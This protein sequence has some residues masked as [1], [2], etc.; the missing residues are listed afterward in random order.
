LPI[1]KAAECGYPFGA[2]AGQQDRA[3]AVRGHA[4]GRLL[5]SE[6]P[7][8]RRD[9]DRFAHGFRVELGNRTMRAG[10]GVVEHDIGFAEPVIRL[11]EQALHRS[12]I[13]RVDCES[14]GAYFRRER[15]QPLGIARRQSDAKAGR[16]EPP[17]ERRADA[18]AMQ[19]GTR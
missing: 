18:T 14:L 2:G 10:A 5:D 16:C 13:R 15:R 12:R 8:K 7:A 3:A 1:A 6:K 17:R 4:P 9:L 11:C 19:T